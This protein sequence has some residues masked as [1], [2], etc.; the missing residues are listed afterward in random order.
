MRRLQQRLGREF[1]GVLGWHIAGVLGVAILTMLILELVG[2]HL[3]GIFTVTNSIWL[4]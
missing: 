2:Q 4:R 1:A 3:P